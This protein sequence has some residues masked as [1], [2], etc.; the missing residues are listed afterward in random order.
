MTRSP[1]RRVIAPARSLNAPPRVCAP[2][3]QPQG[4]KAPAARVDPHKEK[5]A[6]LIRDVIA[7]FGPAEEHYFRLVISRCMRSL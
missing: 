3:Q 6:H 5:I 2:P 1:P 4:A 7:A